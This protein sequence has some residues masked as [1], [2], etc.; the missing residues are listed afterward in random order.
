MSMSRLPAL[1]PHSDL[2][3]SS[4]R[5]H[6]IATATGRFVPKAAKLCA[7]SESVALASSHANF[8]GTPSNSESGR[9]CYGTACLDCCGG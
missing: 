7:H 5:S 4:S 6:L 9:A 1:G 2:P 3:A 8:G